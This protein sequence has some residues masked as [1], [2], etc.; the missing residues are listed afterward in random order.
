MKCS[1]CGNK[2]SKKFNLCPNCGN[3]INIEHLTYKKKSFI[4]FLPIIVIVLLSIISIFIFQNQKIDFE[5]L[6]NSVV[7]IYVYNENNELFSSGS[8]VV[9][10]E[11]NIILTNAH[12]VENNYKIEIISENNTKYQVEGV[13]DY[14]KKKDIAILK[15]SSS[16]GLKKININTNAKIGSEVTAIGSPLGI[17][18]TIST[19]IL[20]N[21]IQS[22]IEVYQHTAPISHGSSGGALFN[23]KGELIGITYASIEEGQNLNLA[24]PIKEFEKEYK[25]VKNNKP[26]STRYYKYLRSSILKTS[27]GQTL[28]RSFINNI[29]N[30]LISNIR[31]SLNCYDDDNCTDIENKVKSYVKLDI[32]TGH[33][34]MGK[35]YIDENGELSLSLE[36]N[37][38]WYYIEIYEIKSKENVKNIE[39]YLYNDYNTSS[40]EYKKHVNFGIMSNDKYVASYSCLNYDKCD[41]VISYIEDFIN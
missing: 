17:K 38:S 10:F 12:V 40:K 3:K 5:K 11:N 39:E 4:F 41:S 1:K 23:N 33:I 29:K 35:T 28:L 30:S 31:T 7:L 36:N 22:N 13:L 24:I 26:I 6:K 25:V 32:Q 19:G 21:K 14:N 8:G 34:D 18:N 2:I 37:G 27:K 15:L 9:A 16:K 20:S